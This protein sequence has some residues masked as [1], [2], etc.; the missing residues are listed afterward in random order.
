VTDVRLGT[1]RAAGREVS[2]DVLRRER[3]LLPRIRI[4]LHRTPPRFQG[5]R[6]ER[7][8]GWNASDRRE[9]S[10]EGQ[11]GRYGL[12]TMCIGHGLAN[13][14]VLEREP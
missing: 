3:V 9:S 12:Q 14:T 7:A 6:Q 1:L 8:T 5:L 2:P 10:L 4:D 13:A 11:Q